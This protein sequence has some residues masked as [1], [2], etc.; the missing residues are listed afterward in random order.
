MKHTLDRTDLRILATLQE[1]GRMSLV[2]LAKLVHL[3]KTPLAERVKRLE[4]AGYIQGYAAILDPAM[5]DL[6]H[7]AFVQIVLDRTTPDVFARFRAAVSQIDAI[8]SCHMVAG[9]FDYILKV[10]TSDIHHYRDVLDAISAAPGVQ[11]TH[12]YVVMETLKDEY[13]IPVKV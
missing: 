2:D 1:H 9:G 8:Q 4:R 11:Q 13:G 10:R 7:V 12:T 3:T 6:G 5:M